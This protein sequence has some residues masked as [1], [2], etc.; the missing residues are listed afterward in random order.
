MN[1]HFRPAQ[2][3]LKP[4][5]ELQDGVQHVYVLGENEGL[6]IRAIEASSVHTPYA[7]CVGG[8]VAVLCL[9]CG[10]GM[11]AVS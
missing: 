10:C 9:E 3:L 5:E 7:W 1:I 6:A 11:T 2:F 8:A 4:G